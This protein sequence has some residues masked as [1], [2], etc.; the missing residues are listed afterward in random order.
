[1]SPGVWG[2]VVTPF[3]GSALSVDEGSLA[4]LVEHYQRIGVAGLT[5]L[6][7]FGEPAHLGTDERRAVV[8]TV[9]DAVDLP[10]VIGVTSLGTA[11]VVEE[12]RNA[13]DAV[14][15]DRFAGAMVQVNS[16]DPGVLSRHLAAVHDATGAPVVVQDYPNGERTDG[17]GAGGPQPRRARAWALT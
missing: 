3:S 16:P 8:E 9:V 11:S 1:L 12:V 5:E 15:R 14:G 13:L 2:V 17:P 4:R 10:L 7:V 6:G